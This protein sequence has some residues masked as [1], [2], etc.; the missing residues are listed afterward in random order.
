MP[1]KFFQIV[2]SKNAE[3]LQV[4]LLLVPSVSVQIFLCFR[5]LNISLVCLMQTTPGLESHICLMSQSLTCRSPRASWRAGMFHLWLGCCLVLL[6]C[7]PWETR[8]TRWHMQSA[9]ASSVWRIRSWVRRSWTNGRPSERYHHGSVF[10][11][12][13]HSYRHDDW[14]E[15]FYQKVLNT[16]LCL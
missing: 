13:E 16:H 12:K 8:A 3:H 1:I 7:Q 14:L 10:Y 11:Y 4:L 5:P 15:S 6:R 2:A 9:T